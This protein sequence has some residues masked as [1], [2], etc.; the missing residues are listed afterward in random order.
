MERILDFKSFVNSDPLLLDEGLKDFISNVKTGFQ[1][2]YKS[3][4]P[5]KIDPTGGDVTKLNPDYE[6]FKGTV[7]PALQKAKAFVAKASQMTGMSPPLAMA[8]LASG[9]TG[10]PAAIPMGVLLYFTRKMFVN[11]VVQAAGKGWDKA[12]GPKKVNEPE[13]IGEWK[14]SL[15]FDNYKMYKDGQELKIIG[16]ISF[17][18]WVQEANYEK[19]DEISNAINWL[20]S[21]AGKGAG[22]LTGALKTA[23]V[24]VKNV[25]AGGIKEISKWALANKASIAKTAFLMALGY[26][27][28]SGVTKITNSV[29]DS[30]M[31]A[32]SG[33]AE[34]T[35]QI[36]DQEIDKLQQTVQAK[37]QAVELSDMQ[38]KIVVNYGSEELAKYGIPTGQIGVPPDVYAQGK[39]AIMDY[40]KTKNV[41]EGVLGSIDRTL[42]PDSDLTSQMYR[43]IA[44]KANAM[45]KSV[46]DF[47]VA[48]QSDISGLSDAPAS[49]LD[50]AALAAQTKANSL[51]TATQPTSV[52]QALDAKMKVAAARIAQMKADH[53]RMIPNYDQ[54]NV[55][56]MPGYKLTT[57][58]KSGFIPPK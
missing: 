23:T 50:N 35:G 19:L 16:N 57:I 11:P 55:R 56:E 1:K 2:G 27:I 53:A 37:T 7:L 26:M 4:D 38:G 21:M 32:V 28:G 18:E 13:T 54:T 58:N 15:D 39:S 41:P 49:S 5:Q 51:S 45:D 40:L 52:Q 47:A 46:G 17:R 30:A 25:I 48:N 42:P 24:K 8:V 14:F 33:A 29:V 31:G 12:F 20:G 6:K 3:W 22:Y 34:Q 10:G 36:P 44:G 43:T 9:I